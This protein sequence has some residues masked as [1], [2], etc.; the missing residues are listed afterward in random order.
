MANRSPKNHSTKLLM[1]LLAKL[2]NDKACTSN[3]WVVAWVAWV[4]KAA[5]VV[6]VVAWIAKVARVAWIAWIVAWIAWVVAWIACVVRVIHSQSVLHSLSCSLSH[7]FHLLSCLQS[8]MK[9]GMT[10]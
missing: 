7:V 4:A 3:P 1:N 6:W 5:R 9:I 10:C 2:A 8:N